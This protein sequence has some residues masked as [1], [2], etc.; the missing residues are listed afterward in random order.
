MAQTIIIDPFPDPDRSILTHNKMQVVE[1]HAQYK[2]KPSD[3]RAARHETSI[4]I[5]KEK[6]EQ[7]VTARRMRR[8]DDVVQDEAMCQDEPEPMPDLD[9]ADEQIIV[10]LTGKRK[11]IIDRACGMVMASDRDPVKVLQGVVALR[12]ALSSTDNLSAMLDIALV[13]GQEVIQYLT[14]LTR[15]TIHPFPGFDRNDDL[16]FE[17]MWAFTNLLC[18]TMEQTVL[19]A[20]TGMFDSIVFQCVHNPSMNVKE[21]AIWALGNLVSD[22]VGFRQFESLIMESGVLE[23]YLHTLLLPESTL[24][25]DKLR[26]MSWSL[27]AF[28]RDHRKLPAAAIDAVLITIGRVLVERV[29][30]HDQIPYNDRTYPHAGQP[31]ESGSEVVLNLTMALKHLTLDGS[32]VRDRV[33]HYDF[34][35]LLLS[36][37]DQYVIRRTA[38]INKSIVFTSILWVLTNIA[39][40]SVAHVEYLLNS[41][42]VAS[43]KAFILSFKPRGVAA[44]ET[45]HMLSNVVAD[46]HKHA[47]ALFQVDPNTGQMSQGDSDVLTHV[48]S[49]LEFGEQRV[50]LEATW[51]LYNMFGQSPDFLKHVIHYRSDVCRVFAANLKAKDFGLVSITLEA[52]DQMLSSESYVASSTD[53]RSTLDRLL[54]AFEEQRVNEIVEKVLTGSPNKTHEETLAERILAYFDDRDEA[55]CE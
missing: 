18:G 46:M 43:F 21:Q 7:D 25:F 32:P 50:R 51:V 13:H 36:I 16:I 38:D 2:R 23:H 8:S 42:T 1:R 17:I 11:R 48:L 34:A 37:L 47:E 20:S 31:T 6:R 55:M 52:I 26:T 49:E 3:G 9:M 24:T 12:H 33:V 4:K 19:A 22:E 5:R 30:V 44:K 28:T 10:S 54:D 39:A 14:Q 15:A 40:G 27:A 41:G 45:F 35:P 53:N 29:F